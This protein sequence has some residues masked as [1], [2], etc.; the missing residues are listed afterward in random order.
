MIMIGLLMVEDEEAIRR[1][2]IHNVDWAEHDLAVESAVNGLDALETLERNPAIRIVVTDIQMPKMNGIELIRE[3][4]RR[5]YPM[6]M[7]VISGFAEFEYARES[8]ELNVADYL[9]KPFASWRLLEVVLRLKNEILQEETK[10]SELN[11]LLEQLKQN[12][13]ALREKL[14]MDLIGG[15]CLSE[16]ADAQLEFLGFAS[17]RN[18]DFLAAVIEIPE[19]QL[20]EVHEEDKYLLNI[21][22]FRLVKQFF[23][24]SSYDHYIVNYRRN[25]SVVILFN[26]DPELPMRL[27]EIL[28]QLH[29]ALNTALSCGVGHPYRELADLSIS[30]KEACS[31]SQYR[32]LYGPNR[33]FS[34]NDLNLDKPSCHKIF[35]QIYRHRIFDDLKIGADYAVREGL[36]DLIREIRNSKM[37]AEL[38]KIVGGNLVLL[39]CAT[40]N[41]LGYNA[42]DIVGSDFLI[43]QQI[44]RAES[45]DQ[46]EAILSGFFATIQSRVYQKRSSLNHQLIE[47][48][49]RYLD[50]NFASNITLSATA[51]HHKISPSYLSLLF[52]EITG[53]KFIDYLTERRIKKAQELL[54][55]SEMK[56][57][58]ISG[59]VGYNDS[60]YFSN[61]FKKLTGVSP[62]DYRESMRE[63]PGNG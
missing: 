63:S 26:P 57:Y 42:M 3:I 22:F 23:S 6:K 38:S 29:L 49:R 4:K 14:L 60:F 48:V 1:K 24:A 61:C 41:E 35:Y 11:I 21:Q 45:L 51:D 9:L 31:A 53:K 2:L 62:S 56:V 5:D 19:N 58:E 17:L 37:S 13:E 15:N 47:E 54:K 12:R 43:L 33:V 34:I 32:Y 39:A 40:L 10:K 46:L 7:V 20:A 27:E 59:A 44:G 18:R 50:E 25:Q 28:N 55:H 8:I 36:E 52:A 30:Y 16:N